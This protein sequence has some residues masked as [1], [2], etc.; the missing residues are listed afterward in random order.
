MVECYV[1]MAGSCSF[2]VV[3][4][5]LNV[6]IAVVSD[7]YQTANEQGNVIFR[8]SQFEVVV[9]LSGEKIFTLSKYFTKRSTN[10]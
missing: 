10:V 1:I 5:L 4:V 6:L 2:I 7:S 8:R 9:D 3:I